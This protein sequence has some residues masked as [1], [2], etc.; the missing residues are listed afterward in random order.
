MKLLEGGRGE[1]A[2]EEAALAERLEAGGRRVSTLLDMPG[3]VD[4]VDTV[5][6]GIVQVEGEGSPM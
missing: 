6:M 5:D 2:A 1:A 3:I 4:I